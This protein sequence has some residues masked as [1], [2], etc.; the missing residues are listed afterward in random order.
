MVATHRWP[1]S[2]GGCPECCTPHLARGHLQYTKLS[3]QQQTTWVVGVLG[4]GLGEGEG[5][6]SR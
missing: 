6:V 4:V 5:R 1:G 3:S 2:W